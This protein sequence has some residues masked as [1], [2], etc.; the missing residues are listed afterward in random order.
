[1]KSKL[2]TLDKVLGETEQLNIEDKEYL[3]DILSKRLI[4]EKRYPLQIKW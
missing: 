3:L 2:I 4:E 1:M